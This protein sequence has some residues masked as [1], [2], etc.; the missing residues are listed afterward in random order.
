M[1]SIAIIS[2]EQHYSEKFVAYMDGLLWNL[3]FMWTDHYTICCFVK[4]DIPKNHAVS[5]SHEF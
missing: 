1:Y 4:L 2:N 3:V 5:N